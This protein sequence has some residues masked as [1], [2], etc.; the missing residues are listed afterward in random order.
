M[1]K[2]QNGFSLVEV[3]II[4]VV[5]AILG[6]AGYT[7]LNRQDQ[8]KTTNSSSSG[9]DNNQTKKSSVGKIKN[10]GVNLGY[11]DAKTNKAGDFVFTKAKLHDNALFMNYGVYIPEHRLISQQKITLSQPIFFR[12][13]PKS[14]LWLTARLIP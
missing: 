11:Y 8:P 14:T 13:A 3:F 1:E 9:N 4:I 12:W 10:I 5:L 7:V 2:N 6:L